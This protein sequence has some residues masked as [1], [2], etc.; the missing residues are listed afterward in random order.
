M[1][2]GICF[3]VLRSEQGN[4][5]NRGEKAILTWR[6]TQ[7]RHGGTVLVAL[8]D[9]AKARRSDFRLTRITAILIRVGIDVSPI[10][11]HHFGLI[12]NRVSFNFAHI[13]GF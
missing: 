9:N 6:V 5:R 1:I 11:P 7:V 8:E 10:L 2:A 4:E 12:G 3:L 13:R